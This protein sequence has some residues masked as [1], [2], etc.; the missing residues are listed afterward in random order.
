MSVAPSARS[1]F[2]EARDAVRHDARGIE[3]AEEL[4]Q[5]SD[6]TRPARLMAG[7]QARA[8]VAV[9]VLVEQDQVAPVR[10]RLEFSGASVDGAS[11]LLVAQ[12]QTRE[13]QGARPVH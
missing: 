2:V 13:A 7:A 11:A 5:P 1:V 6:E 10:V 12:E 4:D 3:N 8:V 9:E